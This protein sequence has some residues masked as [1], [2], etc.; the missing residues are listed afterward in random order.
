MVFTRVT[1][2][3]AEVVLRHEKMDRRDSQ[4]IHR[5]RVA[6]K[7]FRYM[8][9]SLSPGFTGL[10]KRDLRLIANYQRRMGTLQD[11]EILLECVANYLRDQPAAEAALRPFCRYLKHRRQRAL[12]C[13]VSRADDLFPFWFPKC[14]PGLARTAA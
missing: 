12:R 11:L 14:E 3:F 9:E 4:T 2:G 10:G 1:Q 8:V 6:F 7:K 13:C 5:V